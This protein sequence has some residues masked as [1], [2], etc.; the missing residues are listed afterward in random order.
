MVLFVTLALV[1]PR[2]AVRLDKLVLVVPRLLFVVASPDP[3][4][5][6]FVFAVPRFE[7]VAAKFVFV[8]ANP[9]LRFA[10]SV[11]LVAT[12]VLVLAKLVLVVARL[13]ATVVVEA[14]L[15]L[16]AFQSVFDKAP[17]VVELAKAS[18]K[19]CPGVIERPLAVLMVIGA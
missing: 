8:D 19:A 16:N 4:F 14:M 2:L 5:T 15:L 9:V 12:V 11:V 18:D 10:I 13:E 1:V 17:V 6:M 3:R 7:L